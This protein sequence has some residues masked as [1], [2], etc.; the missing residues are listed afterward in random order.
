MC[1]CD[2]SITCLQNSTLCDDIGFGKCKSPRQTWNTPFPVSSIQAATI[3]TPAPGAQLQDNA[4]ICEANGAA[5][6]YFG[7][8]V[9]LGTTHLCCSNVGTLTG[10]TGD[11]TCKLNGVVCPTNQ[12]GTCQTQTYLYKAGPSGNNPGQICWWNCYKNVVLF[13]YWAAVI[14]P[15]PDPNKVAVSVNTGAFSHIRN[16][17]R[18]RSSILASTLVGAQAGI[19]VGCDVF[20]AVSNGHCVPKLCGLYTTCISSTAYYYD[21][22]NNCWSVCYLLPA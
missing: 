21:S 5:D 12:P 13:N 2:S 22:S 19:Q 4:A 18:F 1:Y 8:Q 11:L 16:A 7:E 20:G 17:G 3:T 10:N 9:T 14:L 6:Y 15:H